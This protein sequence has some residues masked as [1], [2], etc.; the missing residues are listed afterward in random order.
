MVTSNIEERRPTAAVE[1]WMACKGCHALVYRKR[2]ERNLLVCPDCGH[3]APVGAQVRIEQ[4]ADTGSVEYLPEPETVEDPL[5]FTDLRPYAARLKEARIRTG[6]TDAVVCARIRVEGQQAV[7]AVMD[8]RFLGGSLGVAVGERL[9]LAAETAGRLGLPLVLVTASGGARMQE[10]ALALMQMAKTSQALAELAERGLLTISVAADPTYGGVAASF[11]TLTDVILC[12]PG[13]RLGFA[14]PRVIAET[15]GEELPAGFQT[16]EFL[17]AQGLIDGVVPRSALR[18]TL[19]RLLSIAAEEPADGYA[20][21]APHAATGAGPRRDPAELVRLARHLDRPTTLDY[22]GGLLDWFIE[23]RGDRMSGDCAAI[24]GGIGSLH[25]RPVMLI[26]HQKGHSTSELIARNFG[27]PTPDG[28]RKAARHMRLAARLGLPII[29][30]IDTQGAE[31]GVKAEEQGQSVAIAENIALMSGL[32]VPVISIVTGEGGSGGALALGVADRVLILQNAFYSVIS[33]EGCA[34]ILW[35]TRAAAA[36]AAAALRIDAV[37]LHRLGV[38]DGIVPE[39]A[40]GAHAD[41]PAAIGILSA[42][43]SGALRELDDLHPQD[44][45]RLRREKFRNFGRVRPEPEL[46]PEQYTPATGPTKE[47]R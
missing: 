32:P 18:P 27:R 14:G 12:E 34:A 28:Y 15:T 35:R 29:T 33:P 40:G 26:G 41:R 47:V 25:G 45:V 23:L 16:A 17:V 1:D 43:V 19:G 3:H 44:L 31:P 10:G 46:E 11:A 24:V 20:D 42:A 2:F 4:L 39:P 30:L 36:E 13:A 21:P 8:F 6:L 37:S 5:D 38:V 22:A 9:V 7:L